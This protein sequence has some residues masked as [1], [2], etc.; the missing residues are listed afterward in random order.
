M[1][2]GTL[3]RVPGS[4]RTVELSVEVSVELSV[5]Q[6]K[7]NLRKILPD[8]AGTLRLKKRFCSVFEEVQCR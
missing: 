7:I 6:I 4:G 1:E 2:A 3:S 8:L 5:S